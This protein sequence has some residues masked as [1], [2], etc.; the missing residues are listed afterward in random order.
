[1]FVSV[2][3]DPTHTDADILSD[4]LQQFESAGIRYANLNFNNFEKS[5]ASHRTKLEDFIRQ[6]EFSAISKDDVTGTVVQLKESYIDVLDMRARTYYQKVVM[7]HV[8]SKEFTDKVLNHLKIHDLAGVVPYKTSI[9]LKDGTVSALHLKEETDAYQASI[10][11]AGQKMTTVCERISAIL[12]GQ[13]ECDGT[14]CVFASQ[15]TLDG[16]WISPQLGPLLDGAPCGEVDLLA[17]VNGA[18]IEA[19]IQV[20]LDQ[21]RHSAVGCL[22]HITSALETQEFEQTA[23]L[24]GVAGEVSQLTRSLTANIRDL[25]DADELAQARPRREQPLFAGLRFEE[26]EGGEIASVAGKGA[27]AASVAIGAP[28]MMFSGVVGVLVIASG[29]ATCTLFQGISAWQRRSAEWSKEED[30]RKIT[31]L[32]RDL[33]QHVQEFS[34]QLT[35][36]LNQLDNRKNLMTDFDI[37]LEHIKTNAFSSIENGHIEH[38]GQGS[39]GGS[40]SAHA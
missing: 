9:D 11:E 38:G 19:V 12:H 39:S 29:A 33:L 7:E 3:M 14:P 23:L 37:Q 28:A 36:F 8:S 13:V 4:I 1:M 16:S 30:T 6:G 25:K 5:K 17:P 40:S 15:S 20:V 27:L 26:A 2:H 22:E 34:L 18:E 21:T 10:I 31:T 24:V 32:I 35:R